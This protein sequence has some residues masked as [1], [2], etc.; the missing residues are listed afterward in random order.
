MVTEESSVGNVSN[1]SVSGVKSGFLVF[2][3]ISCVIGS[4]EST[5]VCNVSCYE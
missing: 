5:C 4:P 1:E 3:V 2:R